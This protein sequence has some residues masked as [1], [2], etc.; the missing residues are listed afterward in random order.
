[1]AGSGKWNRFV[2][3]KPPAIPI[4][5]HTEGT[6]HRVYMDEVLTVPAFTVLKSRGGKIACWKEG[7][8]GGPWSLA[9]WPLGGRGAH[10]ILWLRRDVRLPRTGLAHANGSMIF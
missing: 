4:V 9:A 5:R 8:S 6:G 3:W 2:K 7:M 1:M 10:R